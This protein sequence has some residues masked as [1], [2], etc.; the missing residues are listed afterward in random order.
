M[1]RLRS[2]RTPESS[3]KTVKMFH[4]KKV[5]NNLAKIEGYEARCMAKLPIDGVHFQGLLGQ[6]ERSIGE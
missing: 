6:G 5:T 3:F 4:F 1:Q 2:F